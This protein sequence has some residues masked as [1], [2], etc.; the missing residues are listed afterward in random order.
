MTATL[1]FG[2]ISHDSVMVVVF[3]L[4]ESFLKASV[5]CRNLLREMQY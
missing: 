2:Q 3:A 1:V 4:F 5:N